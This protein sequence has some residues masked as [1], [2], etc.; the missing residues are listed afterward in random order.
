LSIQ[1]KELG[2]RIRLHRRQRNIRQ[3]EMAAGMGVSTPTLR[4]LEKG[5]TTVG[6]NVLLAALYALGLHRDLDKI[7][8]SGLTPSNLGVLFDAADETERRQRLA[9]VDELFRA[10]RELRGTG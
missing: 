10:H 4:R 9:H 7:A 3:E 1:A 8:I 6:L 2:R 5:D